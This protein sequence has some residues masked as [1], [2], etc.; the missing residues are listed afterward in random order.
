MPK[1]TKAKANALVGFSYGGFY[2][3]GYV[4]LF[5]HNGPFEEI[6]EK[7]KVQFGEGVVGRY[8]MTSDV[9]VHFDEVCKQ[10]EEFKSGE[11]VFRM[12]VT[13]MANIIKDVTGAKKLSHFGPDKEDDDEDDSKDTK[14]DDKKKSKKD[15][16]SSDDE[17][18][19]KSS[20]K[21]PAKKTPAKKDESDDEEKE[22]KKEKK[23]AKKTPA[24]DESSDDEDD[25][26]S[27]KKAP[28][29]KAP[30]KKESPKKKKSAD[31]DD[32]S[33]DSDE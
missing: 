27:A 14:K 10:C 30:A 31:S 18:D 2:K 11:H 32:D 17:D 8:A 23:P 13:P 21:A 15:K 26:K 5:K 1:S 16:D 19:K 7:L 33:D 29:K 9:D 25:K 6:Y 3:V 24:K 4:H 28:A 12:N 22:E 20:K